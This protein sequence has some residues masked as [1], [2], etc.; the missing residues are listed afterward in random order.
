MEELRGRR[1]QGMGRM[2]FAESGD[3]PDHPG[4][5]TLAFTRGVVRSLQ[6]YGQSTESI[7]LVV[8]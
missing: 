6:G 5:W 2:K 4:P 8:F 7:V 1:G 3:V